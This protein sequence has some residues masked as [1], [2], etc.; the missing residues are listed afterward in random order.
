MSRAQAGHARREGW[1]GSVL[2]ENTLARIR[3]PAIRPAAAPAMINGSV[4]VSLV[5]AG[6][7]SALRAARKLAAQLIFLAR[8]FILIVLA[9]PDIRPRGQVARFG[10]WWLRPMNGTRMAGATSACNQR[11]G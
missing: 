6:L 3:G 8:W 10:S 1:P 2:R 11:R 4:T 9:S 7:G 5:P